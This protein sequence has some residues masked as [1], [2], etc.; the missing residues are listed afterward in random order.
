MPQLRGNEQILGLN[1]CPLGN[2]LTELETTFNSTPFIVF[3]EFF[4]NSSVHSL[5][6]PKSP[7]LLINL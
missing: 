5:H 1:M 7:E 2:L 3:T 4:N 6:K